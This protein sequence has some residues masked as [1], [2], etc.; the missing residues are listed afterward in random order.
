MIYF[1]GDDYEKIKPDFEK[2]L[3]DKHSEQYRGIDD[4]MADDFE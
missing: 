3:I 2:F 4:N 1:K